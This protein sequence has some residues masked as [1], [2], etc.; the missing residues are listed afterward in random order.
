MKLKTR[1]LLAML[2]LVIGATLSTGCT[3]MGVAPPPGI[4]FQNTESPMG[5][6]KDKPK[7]DLIVLPA[8]YKTGE[9]TVYRFTPYFKALSVGWGDATWE[10]AV[11]SGGIEEALFADVETLNILTLFESY[12]VTVYG[13]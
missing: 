7:G 12:T 8:N 3:K 5:F 6:P 11:K 1:S 2:V 13:K 10:K 4:I 9:C